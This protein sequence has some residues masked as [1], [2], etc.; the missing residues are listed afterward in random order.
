MGRNSASAPIGTTKIP[1][2]STTVSTEHGSKFYTRSPT[3]V[4]SLY[5]WAVLERDDEQYSINQYF[6][7]GY[8]C[9]CICNITKKIIAASLMI[10]L[11][12]GLNKQKTASFHQVLT[13][14]LILYRFHFLRKKRLIASMKMI[15]LSNDRTYV[16]V[17]HSFAAIVSRVK[18]SLF[19]INN[20]MTLCPILRFASVS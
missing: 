13:F 7:I 6:S 2:C 10:S 20:L 18:D 8:T 1:P 17:F 14:V 5:E 9:T 19:S 16:H 3:M 15:I 4:T 11:I 12:Y